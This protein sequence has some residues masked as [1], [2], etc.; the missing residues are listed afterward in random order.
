VRAFDRLHPGLQHHIVNTLGWSDLR[1]LQAQAVDALLDGEHALLLAPTAGGKT[2]AAFFPLLSRM[3]TESWGG[4]SLLYV[5]PLRALLNNLEIRLDAYTHLVGRRVALWHGDIGASARRKILQ[6]PPDCILVTPESLEVILIS[7]REYRAELFGTLRAVVIDEMHAFAGDDRGWHLLSVLERLRRLADREIQRVGLSATIGNPEKLLEWMAG[8]CE[9]K[10]R[11]I[12]VSGTEVPS[13]VTLDYVGSLSNAAEVISRL[14]QGEKRLVFCDSRGRVEDLAQQLRERSVSTFV[15][16]GSL[17]LDERR[18]AEEAFS[19]AANCVIVATSTL[20]LGL[21]VGDLDRVIQIDAPSSVASFL[22]RLGRTGRRA[23]AARNCL[24]L[25]TDDDALLRAGGLIDLWGSGYVEPVAAPPEPLH[26]FAQQVM[27][28]ALQEGGIAQSDWATW[29]SRMPAFA[30]LGQDRLDSLVAHMLAEGILW[31]DQ[32]VIW[33]GEKGQGEFGRKHFL[34]LFSVFTTPPLFTVRHGRAE[35]GHVHQSSFVV[36]QE[37][38]RPILS[39]AGR[40]W[41]VTHVDWNSRTAFVEPSEVTGRS[42]WI[43]SGLALSFPLCRAI[44]RL[45]KQDAEESTLPLSRRARKRLDEIQDGFDWLPNEGT[46]IV[47]SPS[48]LDWWTFG[49]LLANAT[50][51]RALG[52]PA[53]RAD[54]LRVVL[55]PDTD[56]GA[57][58]EKLKALAAGPSDTLQVPVSDD[59][60]SALKFSTCLPEAVARS[61]VASRASD[62]EGVAA[63]LQEP[64]A[65]ISAAGGSPP[66]HPEVR[67]VAIRARAHQPVSSSTRSVPG[68]TSAG[69]GGPDLNDRFR[70]CLLGLAAG[71][72]VGTTLEFEARDSVAP[73]TDMVG[74]GPFGLKPGEWT[75]DTSMALCLA[76]SLVERGGFDARDQMDRYTAWWKQGYLSSNGRCFDIG[77]TVR[78]ALGSYEASGEPFAGSNDPGTAG[79][80]CLMRLAPVVMFFHPDTEKAIQYAPE[81]SKTTHGAAECLDACRLFAEFLLRAFRGCP[82]DEILGPVQRDLAGEGLQ[83][84]A[85]LQFIG[86]PRSRIR[87]SGYVVESLE[88]ALWC[89]A[90]TDSFREAI[91]LA[92]NLGDDADTTAAI[93]GQLAGAHYGMTGIP[94]GW[95]AKLA[96][97]DEIV[98]LADRLLGRPGS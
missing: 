94:E 48:R 29:L 92:A 5:C 64:R 31:E 89:F 22:Q 49:G 44:R 50:L 34:E 41:A 17:G 80:G 4:L 54:N 74:G 85:A 69:G 63:L 55:P 88:A 62:P 37:G 8:H 86:K 38:D 15:S 66:S 73:L 75:D 77:N 82:K 33:L 52:L 13:D 65:T 59:A 11:V 14:H 51:S 35:L 71:D 46:T 60:L 91:L 93:C 9:G 53:T 28:L 72:A 90:E 47:R 45:L 3:L 96:M 12:A 18:R 43:G 25:A 2:E 20:E 79:N 40:S 6:D 81:S 23:G 84:I 1:P 36:S 19:N 98:K 68:A 39:L 26:I 10:R 7:R 95:R 27:A 32:G 78:A 57:V 56:T 58:L 30:E 24:F 70:G 83:P 16:H 97:R 21:D 76:T 42:R 67:R 87:G 61:V